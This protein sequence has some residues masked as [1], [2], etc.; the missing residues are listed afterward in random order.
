MSTWELP[1]FRALATLRGGLRASDV[2][3]LSI[4]AIDALKKSVIGLADSGG[5]R[6]F[7][8]PLELL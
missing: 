3:L 7:L 4:I 6:S 2:A 5:T 8:K 1:S